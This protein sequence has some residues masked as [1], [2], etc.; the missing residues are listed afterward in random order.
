M[1]L[2]PKKKVFLNFILNIFRK[3]LTLIANAF[4]NL[5]TSKNAVR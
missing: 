2:A 3:K 4:L 5:R 1:Q